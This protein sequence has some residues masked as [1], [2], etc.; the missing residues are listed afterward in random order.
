MRKLFKKLSSILITAALLAG[1]AACGSSSGEA[2]SDSGN[3]GEAE[4]EETSAETGDDAEES[5]EEKVVTLLSTSFFSSLAVTNAVNYYSDLYIEQAF[6]KLFFTNGEGEFEGRLADSYEGSEDN[7]YITVHLNEDAAFT[8]GEPVTADDVVFSFRTYTNPDVVAS[9]RGFL[10]YLAG[11]D[12]S[13]AAE[14]EEELGV[15]KVDDHTVII[16]SKEPMD[17]ETFL[18]SWNRYIY[19]FPE[20]VYGQ[21]SAEELNSAETWENNWVG[22]GPFIFD[23]YVDGERIEYVANKDYYLGAPEYDRLIIRVAD[24]SQLATSLLSG[25]GDLT[26]GAQGMLSLDDYQLLQSEEGITTNSMESFNF[27]AMI[28]NTAKGD[29]ANAR[30]RYALNLAIDRDRIVSDIYQGEALATWTPISPNHPAYYEGLEVPGYDPELAKQILEEE[31]FDFSQTLEMIVP[32]DNEPRIRMAQLIQQLYS[33]LGINVNITQYD[34]ATSMAT[35]LEGDFDLG[36]LGATGSYGGIDSFSF[37][38]KGRYTCSQDTKYDDLVNAVALA[39][40]EEE[41]QERFNELQQEIVD[42][43]PAAYIVTTNV[44]SAYNSDRLSNVDIAPHMSQN[45]NARTWI[46]Q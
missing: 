20:H 21:Y 2:S 18:C 29:T 16:R 31:G 36:F 33:E 14:S 19:I 22:S 27:Q 25:E 32:S 3:T 44:L 8:D 39:V 5:G 40:N 35:Y 13:G 15:E 34:L 42:D 12:N 4:T 43:S 45:W 24:S 23:S 26:A 10:K 41:R 11:T 7:T 37:I 30:V 17:A 6:D 38:I 9:R 46:V 1:L 28:F